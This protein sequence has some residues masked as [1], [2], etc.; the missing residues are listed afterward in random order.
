MVNCNDSDFLPGYARMLPE[1]D[2]LAPD[3]LDK[4]K[5]ENFL[6]KLH[7]IVDICTLA[8]QSV[9]FNCEQKKNSGTRCE[10]RKYATAFELVIEF[11]KQLEEEVTANQTATEA[12]DDDPSPPASQ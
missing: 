9:I 12:T 7:N 3:F 11:V 2:D 5:L 8:K 10:H 6:I 1:R 4:D